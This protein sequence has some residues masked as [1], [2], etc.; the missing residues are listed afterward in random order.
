[1]KIFVILPPLTAWA[2]SAYTKSAKDSNDNTDNKNKQEI[3]SSTTKIVECQDETLA[4]LTIINRQEIEKS[5]T[6][7]LADLLSGFNGL[8]ISNNNGPDTLTSRFLKET[9]SGH[10]LFFING[11][12][13]SS[14][15]TGSTTCEHIPLEP[16]KIIET[17]EGSRT[18]LYT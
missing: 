4:S 2:P 10:V 8:S 18:R 12:K 1:M 6:Q 5:Q 11:I 16:I 9:N 17:V 7:S 15:T 13:V 14:A 3:V